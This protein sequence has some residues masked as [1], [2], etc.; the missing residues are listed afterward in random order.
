MAEGA[1]QNLPDG[2][3]AN[4]SNV[5]KR[6]SFPVRYDVPFKGKTLHVVGL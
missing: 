4:P 6:M 3:S 1:A 5:V 2:K